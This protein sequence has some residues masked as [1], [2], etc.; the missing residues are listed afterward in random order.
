MNILP[1]V[2]NN[3]FTALFDLALQFVTKTV[4]KLRLIRSI[5]L[6]I[7]LVPDV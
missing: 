6:D 7:P 2:D 4:V 1:L 5:T 3:P